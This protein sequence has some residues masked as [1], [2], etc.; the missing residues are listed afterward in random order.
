MPS[1]KDSWNREHAPMSRFTGQQRRQPPRLRPWR[2]LV[3]TALALGPVLILV[4][5]LALLMI[6]AQVVVEQRAATLCIATTGQIRAATRTYL[7]ETILSPI[8]P[9]DAALAPD[10]RI[11]QMLVTIR[12]GGDIEGPTGEPVSISPM[13]DA[14]Y[15]D[16]IAVAM[17][18]L[19]SM[20]AATLTLSDASLDE[21]HRSDTIASL[22]E[23]E[24]HMMDALDQIKFHGRRVRNALILGEDHQPLL[25]LVSMMEVLI[26]TTVA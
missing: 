9:P 25:G 23:S 16:G 2:H 5:L 15:H 11:E 22:I 17:R 10:E 4:G 18:A 7:A 12:D 6:A 19:T 21:T 8:S 13:D 26:A 14:A 24:N 3:G 1:P 20:R